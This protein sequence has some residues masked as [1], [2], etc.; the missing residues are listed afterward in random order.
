MRSVC[1]SSMSLKVIVHDEVVDDINNNLVSIHKHHRLVLFNGIVELGLVKD[2]VEV[3]VHTACHW[4]W[5]CEA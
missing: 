1:H 4:P 3:G 2:I 5:S